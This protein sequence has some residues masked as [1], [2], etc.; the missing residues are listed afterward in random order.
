MATYIINALVVPFKDAKAR[1]EI[2]RI[3][4]EEAKEILKNNNF[5]SA[6]GHASTAELLTQLLGI[7]VP[8]QRIQIFFGSGD[9]GVAFVLKTRIEEGKVLTKEEINKIGMDIYLIKRE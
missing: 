2:S 4:I 7:S 1:F 6:V 3:S 9:I 8:S 5:V